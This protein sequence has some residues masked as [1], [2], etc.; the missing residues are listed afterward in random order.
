MAVSMSAGGRTWWPTALAVGQLGVD[1][2]TINQWV[3]RSRRAGHLPWACPAD[4][5]A[6]LDD[7][8][9]RPHLDPPRMDGRLAWYDADQLLATEL[10]TAG[11]EQ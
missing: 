8:V 9:Q 3:A 5:P 6:C 1:R 7:Q 11:C 4:C 10:H 2:K